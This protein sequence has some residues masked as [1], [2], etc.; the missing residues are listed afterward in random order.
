[1]AGGG[2]IILPKKKWNVW[3][4][5]NIE[6]VKRDEAQAQAEADEKQ[7][8]A[9]EAEREARLE[10]LRRRAREA[11]QGGVAAAS[12]SLEATT[13]DVCD[14]IEGEYKPLQAPTAALLSGNT[15]ASSLVDPHA[16]TAA[17]N[18]PP[19]P[20]EHINFFK[21]LEEK[22]H[23]SLSVNVYHSLSLCVPLLYPSVRAIPTSLNPIRCQGGSREYAAEKRRKQEEW[24]KKVGILKPL[25][26]VPVDSKELWYTRSHANNERLE[27]REPHKLA[28]REARVAD[29][30]P[31]NEMQG[32]LAQHRRQKA[33][34][35]AEERRREARNVGP[36]QT[37]QGYDRHSL[38]AEH[39]SQRGGPTSIVRSP[40]GP[41]A[42]SDTS[43]T[44]SW[45]ASS[46]PDWQRQ[47]GH[48]GRHHHHHHH[49]RESHHHHRHGNV[50]P[51][52]TRS[53]SP[54]EKRSKREHKKDKKKHK[55]HHH[56]ERA[57]H[58][59]DHLLWNAQLARERDE[60]DRVAALLA[61]AAAAPT[62]RSK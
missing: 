29:H 15:A 16:H 1:M 20:T 56:R 4:K 49:H 27:R 36:R 23:A 14:D 3:N 42:R 55:K 62:P 50:E 22:Q 18:E 41:G 6:R 51:H 31:L 33:R 30:D 37:P 12:A 24:E 52:Q 48:D 32:H 19:V 28:V 59:T 26:S 38:R 43:L 53:G 39:W 10:L 35:Q 17:S 5:D 61:K 58:S 25:D 21:D 54:E 34:A 7:R 44:S 45:E 2:L 11:R 9:E 8:R 47:G 60:R 57:S 40:H 13:A 46:R